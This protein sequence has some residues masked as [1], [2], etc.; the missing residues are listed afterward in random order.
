M[1]KLEKVKVLVK[2]IKDNN[3]TAYEIGKHTKIST[4]AIQK[5]I[6]G[7]TKNPN[8]TTL[9]ILEDFVERA[10]TGTD[11]K[12]NVV[13]EEI[14]NYNSSK[15]TSFEKCLEEQILL[16]RHINYLESILLKNN[17]KFISFSNQE[18]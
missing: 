13:N 8:N 6:N 2:I 14:E 18:N 5:I 4:F 16:H 15:K 7:E 1:N 3:I 12:E 11:V 10:T 9:S 17:I